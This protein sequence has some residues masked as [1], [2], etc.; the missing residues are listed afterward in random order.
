MK[1]EAYIYSSESL[2][3]YVAPTLTLPAAATDLVF[4]DN[5]ADVR[6]ICKPERLSMRFGIN[7]PFLRLHLACVRG[8][9]RTTRTC[10]R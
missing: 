9:A 4:E 3:D 1:M 8:C 6:Y 10:A 2:T 7:Y 5:Q